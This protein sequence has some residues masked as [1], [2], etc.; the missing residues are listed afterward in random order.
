M[1]LVVG[2]RSLFL[3]FVK[4]LVKNIIDFES[5]L[6]GDWVLDDHKFHPL[7]SFIIN[8]FVDN[9]WTIGSRIDWFWLRLPYC[10]KHFDRLFLTIFASFTLNIKLH[11]F[12]HL[13]R[14]GFLLF[15]EFESKL[16]VAIKQK[17][18]LTYTKTY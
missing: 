11:R 7:F 2:D 17:K 12:K 3:N 5:D 14:L 16:V 18:S 9:P 10:F 6:L 15:I 1:L 4:I 13:I 8:F